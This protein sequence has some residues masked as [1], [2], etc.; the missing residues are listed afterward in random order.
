MHKYHVH[1][2][3][4]YH[5]TSQFP[6]ADKRICVNSC[7]PLLTTQTPALTPPKAHRPRSACIIGLSHFPAFI[8]LPFIIACINFPRYNL[9]GC[10]CQSSSS[11]VLPTEYFLKSVKDAILKHSG[12]TLQVDLNI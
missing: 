6:H 8:S 9:A 1:V 2:F 7:E 10:L 5:E 4:Y 12:A 11:L 3:T